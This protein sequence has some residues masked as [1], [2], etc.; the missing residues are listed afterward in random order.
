MAVAPW[1][2][3]LQSAALQARPSWHTALE[4]RQLAIIERG[5]AKLK[6]ATADDESVRNA[7]YGT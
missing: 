3:R 5:S 2:L 1:S 6:Q 7:L 4:A